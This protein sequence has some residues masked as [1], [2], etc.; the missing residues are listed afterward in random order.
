MR[1]R[2]DVQIDLKG[3]NYIQGGDL[4]RITAEEI[5]FNVHAPKK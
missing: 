1:L 2:G 3:E 4:I 5:E